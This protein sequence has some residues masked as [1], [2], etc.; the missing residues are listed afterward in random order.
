MRACVSRLSGFVGMLAYLGQYPLITIKI[1]K[2]PDLARSLR[3]K[4][5][6]EGITSNG[7]CIHAQ[8]S[9]NVNN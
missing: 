6:F 5:T 2:T 3:D 8:S 9:E 1:Q 7:L 4:K